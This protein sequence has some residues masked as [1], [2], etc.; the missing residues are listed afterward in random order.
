MWLNIL[1]ANWLLK[2]KGIAAW[3]DFQELKLPEWLVWIFILAGLGLFGPSQ[4][5]LNNLGLNLL[6]ITGTLYF[7]QGFAVIS[8]L[9]NK[10]SVPNPVRVVFFFFI[11]IQAY[12]IILLTLLGLADIWLNF[13][14]PKN[15]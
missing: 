7:I 8:S 14:K 12:S 9:F 10:W 1:M 15:T 3:E 6:I 13:R 4:S 11:I 5:L 2:K